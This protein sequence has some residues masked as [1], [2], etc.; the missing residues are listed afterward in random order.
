MTFTIDLLGR[1]VVAAEEGEKLQQ[2]REQHAAVAAAAAAGKGAKPGFA[3]PELPD[4][5][6]V[7]SG[8]GP[9]AMICMVLCPAWCRRL[10]CLAGWECVRR[11]SS[12]MPC[13]GC[14]GA[15]EV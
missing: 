3:V 11:Q 4:E 1:R 13:C 2:E 8:V 15:V 14:T 6:K 9:W 12:Q 7:S 10:R 5:L